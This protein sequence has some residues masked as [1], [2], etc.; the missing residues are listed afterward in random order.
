MKTMLIFVLLFFLHCAECQQTLKNSR[1]T[2]ANVNWFKIKNS[3]YQLCLTLRTFH[4]FGTVITKLTLATCLPNASRQLWQFTGNKNLRLKYNNKCLT[5]D[6]HLKLTLRPCSFVNLPQQWSC[7]QRRLLL[8]RALQYVVPYPYSGMPFGFMILMTRSCSSKN[9]ACQW[10]QSTTNLPVC[11]SSKDKETTALT[12][13]QISS[14]TKPTTKEKTFKSTVKQTL[15]AIPS[16]LTKDK[17][18]TPPLPPSDI[19]IGTNVPPAPPLPEIIAPTPPPGNK[20]V[21]CGTKG[22]IGEVV[23]G[24]KVEVG[25]TPWQVGI[26]RC[27]NCN[28]RCGGTLINDQWVVTAAH[29]VT[30]WLA[31]ELYLVVGEVDQSKISGQEQQFKCTEII[32]HEDYGLGAPFDKDIAL[33]KLD[34]YAVLND[35]VRPLCLPESGTVLGSQDFCQVSGFGR[36]TRYGEKSTFL[37][38]ANINIVD[39]E[40]CKKAYEK[41]SRK[42]T[43]NMLCAGYRKGG[44]DACQGDS[45]GPLTCYNRSKV[46]F[47]LGGIV[48]WG[49]GCAQPDRYGVYTNTAVFTPWIEKK[50]KAYSK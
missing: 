17:F 31:E 48:S 36:V 49:V 6:G 43:S 21:S 26:K 13:M 29:C 39:L 24:T 1:D 46:R 28:I 40:T 16:V 5:F 22:N 34:K 9:K 25:N 45:G 35:Y 2:T 12:T 19:P 10:T 15:T 37:L 30:G 50:L 38:Q 14:T 7:S 8:G 33:L 23:N 41:L 42:V 11:S 4:F 32:T 44:T 27:H 20:N 18:G 47:T 3:K